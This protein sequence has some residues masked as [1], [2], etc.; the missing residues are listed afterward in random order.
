[1]EL[2]VPADG[3]EQVWNALLARDIPPC[4]LG[5]R[6]T[7]RIEAGFCLYGH[8]ID[9]ATSPIAAGLGWITRFTKDFVDRERFE[10]EKA[11]GSPQV[12]R[13]LKMLDRAIPRQGYPIVDREGNEIG[14][15][16]SG[17]M[18]PTLGMGIA[19][20]YIDH[21]HAQLGNEVY[22]SIRQK[23]VAASVVKPGFLPTSR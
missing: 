9:D 22:V 6:D 15:V 5:A 2:Y 14:R 11:T 19:M 3:A 23:N 13:G 12:L 20:G 16:T 10:R 1:V 4:G 7:L 17:T 18:S 21:A 8:E